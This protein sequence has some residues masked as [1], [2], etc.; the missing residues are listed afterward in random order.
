MTPAEREVAIEKLRQIRWEIAKY[1][2]AYFWEGHGK[3]RWSTEIEVQLGADVI[4]FSS[5]YHESY[6]NCYYSK[7]LT[8]NGKKTTC[9]LVNN[10]INKLQ[11]LNA[12]SEQED[13][14]L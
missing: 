11:E 10:I 7:S 3:T 14:F 1:S 8:F 12:A 5:S 2:K 6:R 13:I 4:R 9:T